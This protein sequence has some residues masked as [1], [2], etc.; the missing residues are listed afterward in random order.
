MNLPGCEQFDPGEGATL[1]REQNDRLAQ[2][3]ARHPSRFAGL[4]TL[5]P[6]P[7]APD[8]AADELE[9]CVR[10]LG[11]RGWKLNSHVR[12]TQLDDERYLPLFERAAT[13]GVPVF[14]H[15]TVPHASMLAPYT[16]Y[17]FQLP[18]PS[19][20]FAAETALTAMRLIYSGL[21]D[22]VP[23]LQLVLGHLGEG[24]YFWLYRLDFEFTKPWLG[25]DTRI[26]C[27]Q[28]PSH[29]L[30]A[31]FWAVA[32]GHRQD[33]AFAVVQAELGADRILFGTDYPYEDP[34]ETV[35]WLAAQ[36]LSDGERDRIQHGNAAS[37]FRLTTSR[38]RAE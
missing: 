13:L 22:R 34:S 37:L 35:A 5:C 30:R 20:G 9:R 33:S 3:I 12:D 4:A 11:L 19:L 14:L 31:N 23:D 17:G 26:R 18:G 1:A 38:A 7:E 8:I 25:R 36:S 29:Y 24:L 32:S 6:D 21:F 10:E 28:P 27:S 15:P 2:L 16:G